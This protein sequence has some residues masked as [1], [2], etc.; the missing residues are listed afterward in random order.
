MS[1]IFWVIVDQVRAS[2]V[3][4]SLLPVLI[5]SLLI[6]IIQ[7]KKTGYAL[8]ALLATV[9]SLG[10]VALWPVVDGLT[11]VWPDVM[12]IETHVRVVVTF[13]LAFL[14]IRFLCVIKNMI[15]LTSKRV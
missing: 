1:D 7:S 10:V 15:S 14:I 11:P 8:K 13:V 6:G 12:A 3:G 5:I 9:L 4:L 2:L